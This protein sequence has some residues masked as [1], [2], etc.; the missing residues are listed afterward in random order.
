[1]I[2][3]SSYSSGSVN[4]ESSTKKLDVDHHLR[5]RVYF[6]LA[7]N[8]LRQA[9]IFREE[10][11]I[12]DLYV[13]LLRFSSLVSETIPCHRDYRLSPQSNRI[14]LRK[15][16]L[17]AVAELED[18]KPAVQKKIEELSR[19]S[20]H[21]PNKWGNYHQGN[22]LGHPQDHHLVKKQ[23]FSTCG[24]K[25]PSSSTREYLHQGPRSQKQTL[26]KTGGERFH[27]LSL[28]LTRP[29]EESLT[30]HSILG[31]NG[32][33]G[34]WQPPPTNM[35][36]TYPT[37]V[38]LTPVE[39]PRVNDFQQVKGD[40]ALVGKFGNTYLERLKPKSMVPNNDNQVPQVKEYPSLISFE[41]E[42]SSV[43][44][45]VT[46]QPSPL[47]VLPEGQDL[48]A[49]PQVLQQPSPLPVLAEV[50][51]L[52]PK[53]LPEAPEVE[54]GLHNPLPNN[55][56]C[57][58]DPLQL[59]ISTA[60]MDTFMKLAKS[61]TH[62]N[63]ETCGILAGSLKNR[64][65]YITALIIPK[66]ESTSDSCQATNEEEIFE[67][68]DKRSLFSLGWIHTHPTQS[69]FMSSIDVH[70]QY[71]YQIMLPEAVAIVMAPKDASRSHGIFR[72]TNPGGMTVIRQCPRRGFHAHDPPA[73]GSPIYNNCT[74]VYMSSTLNFD[75]IDLR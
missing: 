27:R 12:I 53:T 31:P 20:T 18:L 43:K 67:V 54:G 26:A 36:V 21:Q 49:S 22:L 24:T 3:R 58:E 32:L 5:L 71:S 60:L 40:G 8:V 29:K 69:C 45:E 9:D 13:M 75:V 15:K 46:L 2:T 55:L 37:N 42:E 25:A 10:G 47:V 51:D 65:F 14:Y 74:D 38:D 52:I 62:N 73:D 23:N 70:T 63:L 59:H 35:G 44:K 50:H 4:I 30:R 7:D 64:I 11:N 72:L 39:I 56:V 34:Q 6:R 1:M 61:N 66:Q 48:T 16:L 19:R 68:Q 28:S 33:H 17:N 57:V 41:T